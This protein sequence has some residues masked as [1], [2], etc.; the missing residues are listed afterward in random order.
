[1]P[2]FAFPPI[3]LELTEE[4]AF[5]LGLGAAVGAALV[6]GLIAVRLR[7]PAI[8][9]YL[10][11]GVA[12][13]PFTP[14]F[15]G[16]VDQISVLAD[17]GIVLLLFA[18]GLEFS[19]GELRDVQRLALPGGVIQIAVILAIGAA[20]ALALG[21]ALAE[22][23]VVGACL[24][25][26]STLVV[27]KSLADRGELDSLHGRGAIGWS[28]IQD[29]ATIVFI[30]V[31]P[32]LAGSGDVFVPLAIAVVKAA[33]FLLLAYVVGTRLLPWIFR[34]VARVGSG[35]LFLLTVVATALLTAFLSS[36]VFGLSLALGAF[37]AG[38]V[39]SE[40]DLSSQAA[41][42][43]IPFRDLFAVLFFVSVGM[44]VDPAALV[45]NAP[46]IAILVVVAVA[47]KGAVIALLGRALG[48]PIRSALLLGGGLA[49][50]GEFSF[51]LAEEGLG[52]ELLDRGVYN[53]ILGTAVITIVLTPFV[54]RTVMWLALRL[55]ARFDAAVAAGAA[56]NRA[57]EPPLPGPVAGASPTSRTELA[58]EAEDAEARSTIVVLGGGRVGRVVV[59][60]VRQRGFGC[61]VVDRD[62]RRLEELA[63]LG[64]STV[65]GDA[66]NPH[67]LERAGLARARV[68]IVAIGDPL[69]ARLSTERARRINPKLTIA[70]RARGRREI[71]A[72]RTHGAGRVADPD[73]EAAF[74]LARHALQRMGVSGPELVGIVTGLRRDAY[75]R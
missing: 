35:E 49:Q 21:F 56:G 64:A 37:V 29:V 25:I 1:M 13:G 31:L 54:Q 74:E 15:V 16:D 30:V 4:L 44:L 70:A 63:K 47:G 19:V 20:I 51:I 40:S 33:V 66:A 23:L 11:A 61:V 39:V 53:L 73:A 55:E 24:S 2:D 50:V 7:Q 38:I 65:F 18:L 5:I 58:F 71:A 67:I 45:A 10:I 48:L 27:L 3:D 22:A 34:S 46:V 68:L 60:A 43:V 75:G 36:A 32:T 8:V 17:V 52:L 57:S 26:S 42:E 72:L 12:I 41:A 14:G 69:T 6:G 28:I 9:G 62:S 59:R